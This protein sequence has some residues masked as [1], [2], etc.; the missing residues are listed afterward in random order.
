MNSQ[1]AK[2]T[3]FRSN[4]KYC[5]S[6]R[7]AQNFVRCQIYYLKCLKS[8]FGNLRV[9]R[10]LIKHY[11]I[12][13]ILRFVHSFIVLPHSYIVLLTFFQAFSIICFI[14]F[15]SE[16]E[17]E[18]RLTYNNN[19]E[20]MDNSSQPGLPERWA[21]QLFLD[22]MSLFTISMC[23]SECSCNIVFLHVHC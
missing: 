22:L 18:I 4:R 15:F 19:W 10:K 23:V 6:N 3:D 7:K 17:K 1:I 2:R 9:C 5:N 20:F 8:S 14:F 11:I 21:S 13:R 16:T 12:L